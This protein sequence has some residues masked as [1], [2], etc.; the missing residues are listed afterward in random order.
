MKINACELG[1]LDT[2]LGTPRDS[3]LIT[4]DEYLTEYLFS[5]VIGRHRSNEIRK[6]ISALTYGAD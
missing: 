3:R 6:N 5:L 4:F 1:D 2:F